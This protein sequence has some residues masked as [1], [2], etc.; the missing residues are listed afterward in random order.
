[1]QLQKQKKTKK[2]TN[3]TLGSNNRIIQRL[4][5]FIVHGLVCSYD[6]VSNSGNQNLGRSI[7]DWRLTMIICGLEKIRNCWRWWVYLVYQWKIMVV[8]FRKIIV[9]SKMD[10]NVR[11]VPKDD[12]R[13]NGFK[14][15]GS[16]FWLEILNVKSCGGL[17]LT[18]VTQT[19]L[20]C[21]F[22]S[23]ALLLDSCTGQTIWLDD[24]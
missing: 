5:L 23:N 15:Q 2:V 16:R 11:A 4:F 19:K 21:P 13:N 6:M 10:R 9:I 20:G 18:G 8:V 17:D 22:V 12:V 1:M 24:L 3:A 14:L 7:T